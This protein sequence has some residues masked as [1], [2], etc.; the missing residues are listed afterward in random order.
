MN[1]LEFRRAIGAD[2]NNLTEAM[3]E[4]ASQCDACKKYADEMMRLNGLIKRALEIP[5]PPVREA[6]AQVTHSR[7]S[8]WYALA[9]SIVLAIGIGGSLWL[10][11]YPR[12]T[13][14]KDVVAHLSD[15]PEAMQRS[16]ARVSAQ[17]LE[18]ALRAKG[19]ELAKPVDDVSYLQSC[20]IRGHLVPHLVVQTDRGPV[21]VLLLTSEAVKSPQHFDEGPYHG[22]VRPTPRGSMAV[23]AY[24]PEL[25]DLVARK[26]GAAIS[27]E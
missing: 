10:L 13:L 15:E 11:G 5:I 16:D 14:A 6:P 27:W 17:L 20:R 4:H 23:I 24:D 18:G 26:I 2:P 25:V 9:A 22:L 3:R 12:D 1:C 8:R 19:L 21:T 7:A